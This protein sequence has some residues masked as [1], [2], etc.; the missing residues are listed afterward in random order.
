MSTESAAPPASLASTAPSAA[1]SSYALDTARGLLLLLLPPRAAAA[2]NACTRFVSWASCEWRRA[3]SAEAAS[4]S[5]SAASAL[6][7]APSASSRS[8]AAPS[9]NSLRVARRFDHRRCEATAPEAAPLSARVLPPPPE[10]TA[11][12]SSSIRARSAGCCCSRMPRSVVC[13]A[14]CAA[15]SPRS[16]KASRARASSYFYHGLGTLRLPPPALLL[17]TEGGRRDGG[18]LMDL[19]DSEG[20]DARPVGAF[21]MPTDGLLLGLVVEV[22]ERRRVPPWPC[23]V[24][25]DASISLSVRGL[26]LESISSKAPRRRWLRRRRCGRR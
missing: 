26:W 24:G 16:S 25:G 9:S 13:A 5:R 18:G 6:S 17:A 7:W 11:F 15:A 10:S 14:R 22:C 2:S 23:P 3:S 19:G 21:L 4:A 1:P 20:L 12:C 8:D